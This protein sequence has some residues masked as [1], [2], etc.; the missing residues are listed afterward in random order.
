VDEVLAVGDEAFARRCL[1]KLRSFH[2]A[3]LTIVVVSYAL[4]LVEALCDRA[5]PLVDGELVAAG[6]AAEVM[7]AYRARIAD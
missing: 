1:D 6:A 2:A 7:A 5:L 3:G 4:T